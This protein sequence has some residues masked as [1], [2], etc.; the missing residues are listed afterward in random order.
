MNCLGLFVII[1]I[2]YK[3]GGS[4][5][6]HGFGTKKV[7]KNVCYNREFVIRNRVC[8]NLTEFDCN[9]LHLHLLGKINY[10]ILDIAQMNFHLNM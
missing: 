2:C 3:M 8:H 10:S 9:S 4:C 1:G 7:K 5:T 6:K